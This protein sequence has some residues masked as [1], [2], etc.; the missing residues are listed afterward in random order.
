MSVTGGFTLRA[1]FATVLVQYRSFT[2]LE[3]EVG[4]G[5][6]MVCGVWFPYILL[7]SWH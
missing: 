4:C 3:L 6:Y 5:K 1:Q 2:Q 7:R